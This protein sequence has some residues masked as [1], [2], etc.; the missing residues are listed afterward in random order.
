MNRAGAKNVWL[1]RR[2]GAVRRPRRNVPDS[3]VALVV[4]LLLLGLMVG[5]GLAMV[6]TVGSDIM[7]NGFYRNFRGSFYAADSGLN[8]ARQE[9]VNEVKAAVPATFSAGIPPLP[10]GVDASVQSSILSRYGNFQSFNA[11][12]AAESWQGSYKV[13]SLEFQCVSGCT[14]PVATSRDGFGN[15]TGY[16]YIFNYSLTSAG[17][18]QGSG[19][20]TVMETGSVIFNAAV[21]PG[22]PVTTSFAAYGMFIDQQDLC[23]G[24]YLVP[25][26]ISG[27]TFT[28]G[29][30][31]FGTSGSYIFSDGVG[32]V[33]P[34]AGFQFSGNCYQSPAASY[35]KG[36][37]TIKPTFQA[38]LTLGQAPVP[39]P[40]N[41]FSQERAVLD[42]RGT[43]TAAVTNAERNSTLKTIA[44]SPYPIGGA[45]SG[46]YVPYQSV[47]GVNTLTGGGIYAEGNAEVRLSIG[48]S[49]QSTP[50]QVFSIT[51]G[52][53][54]TTVTLDPQASSA[55]TTVQSGGTSLMLNGVPTD[56]D[57]STPATM[58]YVNGN[59]TKL[60]GPGQG[61]PA[62]QDGAALTI[63]A[64][65]D[66]TI[67]GD[68]L[69]K[70][71]PVTLTQNLIPGTPADTLI[72]GNDHDQTLGI[73]TATGNI[74]LSNSQ[75]NKNLQ[76]DASLATISESG[77]GGMQNTGAAINT[78]TIV[79]GRI[80]SRIKNINATTRNVFFDRRYT[81]RPGFAP[82]WFP[83][84]TVTP[85]GVSSAVVTPSVQRVRWVN[86]TTLQ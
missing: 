36:S 28:N 22:G 46:V 57:H 6:L 3:G 16:Q 42:G 12:L 39:L 4:T 67:T 80:Q 68:I 54:V 84:T 8:I 65:G 44:G 86:N 47:G 82:P 83:A 32:S 85:P 13:S 43:N 69:Y 34:N 24:S 23:N 19:Q 35:K 18:A 78:L 45:T 74:N 10:S 15:P 21:T 73:F 29:G 81:S 55:R 63:T 76:I 52:T 9:L 72:P 31:T 61:V 71:E 41:D 62:V 53:T 49:P 40:Q 75:S 37:Q 2:R 48:T 79:G 7:I 5:L 70:S 60:S 56:Q 59:I 17:R 20:A 27:P 77:T 58:L 26:T 33:T 30:W 1:V 50:T 51:Q 14:T 25:G 64:K 11:G 66:V 38:G